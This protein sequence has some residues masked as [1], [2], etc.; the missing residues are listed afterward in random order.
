CGPGVRRGRGGSAV[1]GL[2]LG[3][4]ARALPPASIAELPGSRPIVWVG[5]PLLASGA[6]L[7]STPT[8]LP[9]ASL[10]LIP[11]MPAPLP[12]RLWLPTLFTAPLMSSGVALC[13]LELPAT[14]VL[15]SVGGTWLR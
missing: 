11:V 13:P 8:W 10:L 7:G 3:S 1:R 9:L 2:R 6:S 14:I 4:T 5:P 15:F 12:T